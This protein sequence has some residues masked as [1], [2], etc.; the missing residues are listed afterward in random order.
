MK[1]GKN[2][3]CVLSEKSQ[4]ERATRCM[5]PTITLQERENYGDGN[6]TGTGQEVWRWRGERGGMNRWNPG[7]F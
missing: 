1:T 5:I 6:K 7:D 4:C 2:L 3:K